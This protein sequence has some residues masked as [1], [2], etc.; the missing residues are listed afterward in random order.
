MTTAE[1]RVRERYPDAHAAGHRCWREETG[2]AVFVC[3]DVYGKRGR[4]DWLGSGDSHRMA[5]K[6]A[7]ARLP[8]ATMEDQ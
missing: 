2:T 1:R 5:W 3:V 4:K 8:A 6:D 7:A